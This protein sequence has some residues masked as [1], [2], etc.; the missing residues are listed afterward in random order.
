MADK[1]THKN[2]RDLEDEKFERLK[3]QVDDISHNMNLLMEVVESKLRQFGDY[4]GSN[5]EIRS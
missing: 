1:S 5:S 4:G 3:A 2:P